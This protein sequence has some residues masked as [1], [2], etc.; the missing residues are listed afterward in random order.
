MCVIAVAAKKRHMRR[1]E[2]LEAMRVN[3]SGF[4]MAALH[5]GG[6]RD[7]LRTLDEN[8]AI[9]FFDDTVKEEDAFVMHARI[10]SRGQKTLDNVHGWECDGVIFMHNMTITDLD[11][12]MKRIKWDGTDSE[13]FFRK[14]F[15]PYYRGL[16]DE[17]YKDHKFHPDLDNIIQH[18][19][20]YQNKFCFIMPDNTVIRYGTWVSEP[21]RK[22]NGEIAFYA[23]NSSYKVYTANRAYSGRGGTAANTAGFRKTAGYGA[24]GGYGYDDDYADYADYYGYGYDYGYDKPAKQSRREKFKPAKQQTPASKSTLF[25]GEVLFKLAG[26]KGVCRLAIAHMVI[27]NVIS[28]R[29]V[30]SEDKTEEQVEKVVRTLLPACFND[31]YLA[32][33]T[34]F[35]DMVESD[36]L[37][38][39]PEAVNTYVEEFAKKVAEAYEEKMVKE[40]SPASYLPSEAVLKLAIESTCSR[41]MV[42]LRLLNITLNIADC[43]DVTKMATACVLNKDGSTMEEFMFEDLFGADTMIADDVPDG[44]QMLVSVINGTV[45]EVYGT[46]DAADDPAAATDDTAFKNEQPVDDDDAAIYLNNEDFGDEDAAAQ[47]ESETTDDQAGKPDPEDQDPYDAA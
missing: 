13:F 20:G 39:N 3:S 10:P 18:F 38:F 8:E 15:I 19:V 12:M 32:V 5:P 34:A 7:T 46:D 9:K 43:D 44:L 28:G 14:I 4:F 24:Y 6:K 37:G 17:A 2:V 41:I 45:E 22:E 23:S 21:D 42:L 47:Q 33:N 16:G 29:F 25:D 1:E 30:Y 35:Q 11:S 31:T 26:V 27:E 36:H 40:R